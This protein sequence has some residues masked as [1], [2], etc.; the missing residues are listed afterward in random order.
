MV[1]GGGDRDGVL[2]GSGR[3]GGRTG[4]GDGGKAISCNGGGESRAG[5][6][7]SWKAQEEIAVTESKEGINCNGEGGVTWKAE[8]GCK[9]G[10]TWI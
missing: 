9:E 6:A 3:G 8:G 10:G 7:G 5:Q 1:R 2:T 4:G